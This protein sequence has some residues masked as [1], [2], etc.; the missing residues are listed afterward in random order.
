MLCKAPFKRETA[1][2]APEKLLWDAADQIKVNADLNS[3]TR[4]TTLA[5]VAL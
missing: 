3:I 5:S 2:A 4:K 1:N